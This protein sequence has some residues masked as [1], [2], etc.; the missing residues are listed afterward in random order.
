MQRLRQGITVIEVRENRNLMRNDLAALPW[1]AGQFYSADNYWEAVGIASALSAGIDP[2][3]MRRPIET[4]RGQSDD[5][6]SR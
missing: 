4:L 3:S 5:H 6:K 1:R 2:D